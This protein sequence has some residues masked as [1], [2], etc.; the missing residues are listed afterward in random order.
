[1]PRAADSLAEQIAR[2]LAGRIIRNEL[3]PRERIREQHVSQALNVSRGAVREALLILQRRHLINIQSNCGAQVSELTPDHVHGL[4]ALVVELYVLLAHTV[5]DYWQTDDDLQPLRD[6]HRR[7]LKSAE[8]G[9][10]AN[11]VR[12]SVAISYVAS[13]FGRNPYLQSTLDNLLPVVSRT[14]QLILDA[15]LDE[16]QFF[17]DLF[18]ELLQSVEQRDRA[19][20]RT[21]LE[22]YCQR[23]CQLVIA[24]L[25][26]QGAVA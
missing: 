5:I 22:K 12:E 1:M 2:E 10:V 14:H 7:M 25:A 19:R 24:A 16:M 3:K 17:N 4:Y 18:T 11:F 9:D 15:R 26:Q 8:H 23:N 21:L 20:S 6:I 13:A